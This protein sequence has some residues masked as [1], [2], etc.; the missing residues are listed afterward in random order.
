MKKI[1]SLL[2]I[3]AT[4]IISAVSFVSCTSKED[5]SVED[6][7]KFSV[8]F[9]TQSKD[10]T[11]LEAVDI[12]NK[13]LARLYS[14]TATGTDEQ[15]NLAFFRFTTENNFQKRVNELAKITGDKSLVLTVY[16]LKNGKEYKKQEYNPYS[17]DL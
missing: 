12:A 2:A 14:D 7:Y 6:F 13:E 16:M 9:T 10:A 17:I 11:V 3:V 4:V 8:V 1:L 15:A 5:S